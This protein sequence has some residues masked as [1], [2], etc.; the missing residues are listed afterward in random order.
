[1]RSWS[2]PIG[3]LFGI[4]IRLHLTFFLLLLF[5]IVPDPA[6]PGGPARAL[7]LVGIVF[8]CVVLHELGHA[9]VALHAGQTVRGIVLLPIGGVTLM[10]TTADGPPSPATEIRVSAAGPLVNFFLAAVGVIVVLSVYP[11]STEW[12][13]QPPFIYS[14]NLPRT[15]VWSN[16][17]LGLFNLLPAY[18][19]DGGRMLRAFLAR[20]RDYLV[21]T[22]RAVSIG[23]GFAILFMVLG[24]W[25][26]WMLLIG[27]FLFFGAQLEERSIMFQSVL[28]HVRLEDVMLTDF[29][30]LSPADT[31]EDALAKAVHTLQDDFPVIR[32]TDMVGVVSRQK[33]LAALRDEGNAYVQS[34]MNKAFEV[35]QRTETLASALKKFTTKELTLLPVVDAGRL[36]GIVTLQNLMHSMALLSESKKIKRVEDDE[37][38]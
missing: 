4:D 22:R 16:I 14:M 13:W 11:G 18:P 10:D 32:G 29:R 15:F 8:G 23:Q 38:E 26:P 28:E 20:D 27:L 36:I 24:I 9:V 2:I 31:L 35:A 25:Q 12:L 17:Y 37:E 21:A 7:A 5:V 30:T 34:V 6:N 3:R 1:M 33:I 19:M